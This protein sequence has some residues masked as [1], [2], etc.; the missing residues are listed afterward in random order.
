MTFP[1]SNKTC[2]YKVELFTHNPHRFVRHRSTWFI[3]NN[4]DT[5]ICMY[6]LLT[7]TT[8][9]KD[10]AS[11]L[12][13]EHIIYRVSFAAV[14]HLLLYRGLSNSLPFHFTPNNTRQSISFGGVIH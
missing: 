2:F 3:R 9:I 11:G 6:I 14:H 13:N 5:Y 1:Q 8:L 12:K 4:I 7:E 10:I